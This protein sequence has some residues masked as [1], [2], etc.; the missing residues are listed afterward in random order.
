MRILQVVTSLAF[1]DA[2]GNDAL[3]IDR[4]LREN[5]YETGIFCHSY[6]KRIKSGTVHS[7]KQLPKL[8]K[9][10]VIL[11][12][13]YGYSEIADDVIRLKSRIIFIYHNITPP[14]YFLHYDLPTYRLCRDGRKQ[15]VKIVSSYDG[16][17]QPYAIIAASD[18]NKEDLKTSGYTCPI[19]VCPI[20]IPFEDYEK[21]PNEGIVKKYSRSVEEIESGAGTVN[22]VFVGRFAPNKHQEDIIKAFA[23]YKENLT[24]NSRL[25]LVG[26]STAESYTDLLKNYCMKL[27]VKDSVYFTEKVPFI[28]I[29]AYYTVADVFLCMSTHEGFCVPLVEAMYFH[30]PIIAR[31]VAAIPD[32]LGGSGLLI[33]DNNPVRA[34]LLIDKIIKDKNLRERVIERQDR[35]LQD[36]TYEHVG[37]QFMKVLKKL[38]M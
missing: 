37:E 20:L 7:I 22:I 33:D 21:K 3:A 1:G 31:N 19:E 25:F 35:R 6:D 26:G 2:V 8:S 23:W 12:H 13:Y 34:G 15:L 24:L 17:F 29:L 14:E 36:F 5:G 32:T 11:F 27:Q 10:D 18:Y 4:I 30:T 28:D 9:E 38:I 16:N